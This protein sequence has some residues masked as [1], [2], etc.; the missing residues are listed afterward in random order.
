MTSPVIETPEDYLDA[1]PEAGQPWLRD[2]WDYMRTTYPEQEPT[3]FR[4]VPMFKFGRTY[5]EGYV[6]FTAAKSHFAVH[7]IDFD[8]VQQ[9]R[10]SIPG[11]AGGKGSVSVKYTADAAKPA[12]RVFVDEVMARHGR[13]RRSP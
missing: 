10:A 11:A 9:A 3:M 7:A 2:F 5:Q 12:L 1:A 6:M 8:L 4:Q 13:S